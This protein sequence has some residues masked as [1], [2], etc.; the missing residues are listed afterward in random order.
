MMYHYVIDLCF[1]GKNPDRHIKNYA[2]IKKNN[3]FVK[4]RNKKC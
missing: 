4:I 1:T 3:T 2:F